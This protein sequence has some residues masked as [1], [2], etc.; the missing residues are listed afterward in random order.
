MTIVIVDREKRNTDKKFQIMIK[1]PYGLDHCF[2]GKL[3]TLADAVN[4]C[5][6][7]GWEVSAVG[8]F[9]VVTG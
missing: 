9:W 5:K 2:P 3:F 8:T 6:D 4:T 1:V 7:K